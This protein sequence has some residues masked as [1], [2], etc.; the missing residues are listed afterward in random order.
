MIM[1]LQQVSKLLAVMYVVSA[2]SEQFS[3]SSFSKALGENYW[4][5]YFHQA[6]IGTHLTYRFLSHLTRSCKV[7][8]LVVAEAYLHANQYGILSMNSIINVDFEGKKTLIIDG[9]WEIS[10]MNLCTHYC[11]YFSVNFL[12]P[13]TLMLLYVT[14]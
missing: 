11:A 10:L 2:S 1:I 8:P 9:S 5:S 7:Q 6:S 13:L 12:S 14:L 3:L 4:A